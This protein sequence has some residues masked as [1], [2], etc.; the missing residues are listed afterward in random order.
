MSGKGTGSATGNG[1]KGFKDIQELLR[2]SAE[3]LD[4]TAKQNHGELMEAQAGTIELITK[5]NDNQMAAI[6]EVGKEVLGA[7]GT[8]TTST[9]N[10]ISDTHAK[11]M[12]VVTAGN[13]AIRQDLAEI[14]RNT[15]TTTGDILAG[16]IFGIIALIIGWWA[17]QFTNNLVPVRILIAGLTGIAVSAFATHVATMIRTKVSGNTAEPA[18][19]QR[20]K[21]PAT[22]PTPDP[23]PEPPKAKPET[24]EE[25]K[26]EPKAKEE[27]K[28][29]EASDDDKK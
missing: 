10:L 16:V 3:K 2:S 18:P 23:K 27:P 8:S 1:A 15:G 19:A 5:S 28:A 21:S 20:Q 25:P 4:N 12:E 24:K 9:H 22:S 29:E 11:A 14:K 13:A 7:I 17:S 6:R 26:A